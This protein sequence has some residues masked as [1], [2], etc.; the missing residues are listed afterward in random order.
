MNRNFIK[1]HPQRSKALRDARRDLHPTNPD[2]N[3]TEK[4]LKL[5]EYQYRTT[6]D[7]MGD[8]IHVVNVG[9]NVLFLNEP[10]HRWNKQLG[11]ETEMVGK[12]I[13]EVY[14]FLTDKVREEYRS[15]LHKRARQPIRRSR[16]SWTKRSRRLRQ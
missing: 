10:F 8:A 6:L 1:K 15:V 12:T 2:P 7:S 14:P 9:L 5:S 13:F 16:R 11:L 4:A 3:L